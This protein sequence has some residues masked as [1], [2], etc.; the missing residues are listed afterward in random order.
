MQE[1]SQEILKRLVSLNL[2]PAREAE[3]V[4]E[5][6]QHLED[7][8]QELVTG[9]TTE[10]EARR[11]VL[12]ELSDEHLPGLAVPPRPLDSQLLDSGPSSDNLLARGL[13]QV[14][15]E[16]TQEPAVPGGEGGNN[17]LASIWQDVR[18]GL[19][20]LRQNPGFTLAA[21]SAISL[22]VGVNVGIFSAL[23]GA[24][25]RLLPVP[26]AEQII[27]VSQIFRGQ[28]NRDTHGETSM[29]SYTEYLDYRDHNHVFTGVVAYEPFVEANLGGRM[30]QL[31]GAATSCNYFDVLKEH[32]ALGRGFVD[33]DCAALGENPVVVVSDELWRGT[34]ASDPY[35]LGKRIALNR[36]AYTVVGIAPPGFTGTEPVASA[37]WVP[38]TMQEALEPGRNR[39]ADDNMSWL[40][41]LG[42]V[43]PGVRMGQ[44]RADLGFIAERLDQLH[45]GRK[46]ALQIRAATFLGRP[47]ERQF[48]IPVASVIL[49]AFGLVLLIACANVANLL[50]ARASARHKEIALRLSMGASRWRLVRQ[51]LTESLLLSLLGGTLGSVLS[52]WSFAGLTRYVT[53]HLS[54]D[55]PAVVVNVAPDFR[56]LAYAFGLTLITGIAFGLIPALLSTRADL[57]TAL[58]ED[59][60]HGK[61][62]GRFL[63][64][65]LVSA[66]VAVCTIL[67]LA[68][69]LL[70]RALYYAQTVNPGFEMK[71]VAAAFLNLRS[72]GYDQNRATIFMGR[73]RERVATVPG[74]VEIAQAEC[75]PLSHDHSADS[76][77]VPGRQDKVPIEYN[78]VSPEYFPLLGIPIVLGRGFRPGET[79]DAPGVIVTQSTAQR[80]WPGE[81]PLGKTLRDDSGR[82]YSVIGVTKDAQVSHLGELNTSY[83]YFP[84]GQE[85]NVR[86][87]VLIRF[88]GDF[89]A[90]AKDIRNAVESIDAEMPVD[91]T[92]LEDYL[93]KWRAPS[94]IAATLAGALGSLALLL[95]S[96]GVYGMVS[97]TVSRSRRDIGI[98]VAL[99]AGRRDVLKLV[100]GHAMLLALI[101]IGV[102][103]AGAFAATRALASLL[104]GISSTD[105]ATFVAVSLLLAGVAFVASYIPALRATKVDPMVALRYE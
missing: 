55:L 84:A 35:I 88:T 10:D 3:I 31:L 102:G 21:V 63:R 89:T 100:V 13:R 68:T 96:I 25:L 20:M 22:G 40:A 52:F 6:A 90:T 24:A 15:Q 34:F 75:A 44:V 104:Y 4:E 1:W 85:D 105:P 48:L 93:E 80:V 11:L 33:S 74:V 81:D 59:G 32:P 65:A 64:G 9:G 62:S 79:H 53:S 58:R 50:L 8:F 47:E 51:F 60:A 83:L 72:Q 7:R 42:R 61:R 36:T 23:D 49:A 87:Y 101:G 2:P 69:G 70:L 94:R 16:S 56:V 95:A 45:P 67:L 26:R 97:C 78:H 54:R 92:R 41:L 18:Y 77:T 14:E 66:Q 71:N 37:F 12:R 76:F 91:V 29:F 28:F 30:Q 57:N 38:I 43:R 5:V 82:E 98:R 86:T 17:F 73:L 46:T 19:R 39:L 27:S 103:L 99:G